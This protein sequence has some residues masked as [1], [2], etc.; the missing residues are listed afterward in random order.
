VNSLQQRAL[1]VLDPLSRWHHNCH[2][3]ALALVKAGIAQRVARGICKGVGSQHSW[4]VLGTDCY[5]LNTTIIDPTLW[6][7]TD[8]MPVV[9]IG[10]L[11]DG[12]HIPH[13]TGS[14]WTWG[15]PPEAQGQPISLTPKFHLSPDAKLFLEIL[16]PL[17]M[18]GWQILSSAPVG[19]WPA[20]EIFAAMDDTEELSC[21]VP[22]DILGMITDR[23]PGGLY[24]REAAL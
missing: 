22:V 4:A 18:L 2:A 12:L 21:L 8:S 5:D 19:G 10:S 17:D 11:K 3:A 1:K 24:L 9:W 14:I 6:S 20:R 15:R 23:N 16:G 13:G 7:Y